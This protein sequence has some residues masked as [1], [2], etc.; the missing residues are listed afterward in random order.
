MQIDISEPEAHR[1][2]ATATACSAATNA[3]DAVQEDIDYY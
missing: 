1:S 2:P 3:E